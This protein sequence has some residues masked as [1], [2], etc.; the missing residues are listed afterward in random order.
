ME[1]TVKGLH[2]RVVKGARLD[3]P[4]F[5]GLDLGEC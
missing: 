5:R 4:S 2:N 1:G 3:R